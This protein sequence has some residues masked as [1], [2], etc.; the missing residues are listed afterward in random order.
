MH[1]AILLSGGID[2]IALAYWRRPKISLTINYGQTSAESEIRSAEIVANELNI[3]HHIITVDCSDLGSGDLANKTPSKFAP[4]P[5]WWPYR[6]QFLITIAAM[7]ALSLG[8]RNI[9]LGCVNSDQNHADGRPEFIKTL[10]TL[11]EMQ[12]GNIRITAPAI[13]FSTVELVCVAKI[14]L[15]LLGWAHSCH[16]SNHPCGECRGCFKHRQVMRD[17]GYA[18]Y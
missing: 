7:K 8:V 10:S 2:S 4:M 17:L 12:E 16:A 9:M 18:S 3:A 14:P 5:E 6:N 11:V 13:S 15:S 1:N